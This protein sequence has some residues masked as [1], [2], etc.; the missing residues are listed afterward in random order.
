MA[1]GPEHGREHLRG[2]ATRRGCSVSPA[3]ALFSTRRGISGDSFPPGSAFMSHAGLERSVASAG[4]SVQ[5]LLLKSD[6]AWAGNDDSLQSPHSAAGQMLA[7]EKSGNRLDCRSSAALSVLNTATARAAPACGGWRER[8][9]L[10]IPSL[11]HKIPASG[12]GQRTLYLFAALF[13]FSQQQVQWL[14]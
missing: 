6:S 5:G 7:F 1:R 3:N 12:P 4:S 11:F 14:L 13:E 9:W 10:P 8:R 2:T